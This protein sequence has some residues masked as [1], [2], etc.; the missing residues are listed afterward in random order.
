MAEATPREIFDRFYDAM[1]RVDWAA[2]EA[3]VD[4]DFVED[5]PQS[6]ERIRGFAGLRA[7]I[8]R[9]PDR[10]ESAA[11]ADGTARFVE[12]LEPWA[13][14]PGYTVIPVGGNQWHS[15]IARVQY[16][17]GSIWHVLSWFQTRR[18]R[19]SRRV[20]YFAPEYDRPAWREDVS[21]TIDRAP[22]FD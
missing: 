21:E 11:L 7:M 16:P 22:A 9:Y 12:N 5:L 15:G 13:M 10:I 8:E 2:L 17:D 6:G 18:G 20:T 4:P 1:S 14:T 3:L 19:I